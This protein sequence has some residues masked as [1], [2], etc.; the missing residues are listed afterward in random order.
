[1]QTENRLNLLIEE[2]F[3]RETGRVLSSLIGKLG[4]FDLAED[5]LQEAFVVALERWPQEG[6]PLNPAAWLFTTAWRKALDRFRRTSI[7][8]KK[9][10]LLQ[11]QAEI[12][13]ELKQADENADSEIENEDFHFPDERLKLIF[14]CCHPAL[15]LEAQ[16]ALTLHTLGGLSTA[17]IASAFLV[18]TTTMAQRLVRAKRKIREAHI[19]YKVPAASQLTERLDGVLSVLYL[20]FNA[21]Y[22]ANLGDNLI[23]Q[24][25]C[26]EAIRL[27]RNL[28]MLLNEERQLAEKPE[29]SGLFALMLLHDSRRAARV[30][31]HGELVVLEEQD[32]SLWNQAQIEEGVAVL[33]KALSLRQPGAYQIQAAISALHAQAARPEDTDWFQ[34]AMLYA[35]LVR[36][37]RSAVIR[38]NWAVAVAMAST[39]QRGLEMLAELVAISDLLEYYPYHAARADL[40]RR[41]GKMIEAREAYRQALALTQNSVE[42]NFL[43]RRLSEVEQNIEV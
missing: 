3:H 37:T 10:P 31:E 36:Y 19:P 18:P 39:P 21:G 34:I 35:E 2:T 11:A 27:C 24:E 41:A 23:R 38:L 32:R 13:Q 15:N 5:V 40:L 1:M 7:L 29:A 6:I 28:V 33:E 8:A 43:R 25:L 42:Q 20:I 12:E 17:E 26:A 30:N 14:T 22:T 4:D 9:Q 16:V